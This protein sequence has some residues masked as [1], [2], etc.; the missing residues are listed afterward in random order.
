MSPHIS[1]VKSIRAST[2]FP[3]KAISKQ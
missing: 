3:Y 1:C 2:L